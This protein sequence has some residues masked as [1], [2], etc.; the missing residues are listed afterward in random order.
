MPEG[1]N[2]TSGNVEGHIQKE[3]VYSAEINCFAHDGVHAIS[4]SC[5]KL[6]YLCLIVDLSLFTLVT[7]TIRLSSWP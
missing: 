5:V 3:A 6:H 1:Q 4:F 7:K 2:I